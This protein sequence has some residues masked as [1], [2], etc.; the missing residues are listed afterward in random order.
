MAGCSSTPFSPP[1]SQSFIVVHYIFRKEKLSMSRKV[2]NGFTL[3][4]LLVVIA[5][6]AILAAILFPVFAQAREKARSTSCLSNTKQIMTGIK[7]YTQDYDEQSLYNWYQARDQFG[8]YRTWMELINPYVKNAQVFY[9]PSGSKSASTYGATGCDIVTANY[10]IP[11][12]I[13]YD[14]YNWF[15]VVMFAGFVTPNPSGCATRTTAVCTSSEFVSSPAESAYMIEGYM[16]VYKTTL[17]PDFGSAC[18]I[19][20]DVETNTKIWR[21]SEGANIAFCDG[22]SKW[23]KGVSFMKNNSSKANYGGAQ[24]PQSPSMR[25]GP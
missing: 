1:V 2:R 16:A 18:T 7:M 12:W 8:V 20:F 23:S 21:H 17:S 13:P 5:I 4:E 3:I 22:H 11:T 24:Y 15:G 25:V 14:Y 19:G 9:C 10:I 6:I